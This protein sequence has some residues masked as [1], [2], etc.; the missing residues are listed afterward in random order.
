[1]RCE[2]HRVT[3]FEAGAAVGGTW[4]YDAGAGV[5]SSMY[6]ALRT[7]LP[8]EL[9]AFADLPFDASAPLA[10]DTRRYCG[11]AEVLAY[12]ESFAARNA[13]QPLIRFRTRVQRATPLWRSAADAQQLPGPQWEV[14]TVTDGDD[15]PVTAVFDALVVANGHYSSPRLPAIEGL[16][17]FPGAVSHTH[18]YRVPAP[19]AGK[20]VLV[21]GAAASG[22]DISRDVAP[23]AAAVLLS[24]AAFQTE[25]PLAGGAV[26]KRA[27]LVRLH[28]DG[29]AEFA[30]GAR[31]AVDAV[32]F[33]TGYHFTFPFL[34]GA[35]TRT[36]RRWHG[37]CR[38]GRVGMALASISSRLMCAVRQTRAL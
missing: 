37:I 25:G 31:D 23:L 36:Q 12:L 1:L 32:L 17:S 27:M 15:A 3:V 34:D 35:R 6:S 2:G 20:R 21:V 13:L 7:N 4:R 26:A 16:A 30:D 29:T 9:M 33:A 19:F 11:H 18:D 28:A 24:A 5:H 22:E 8:R 10:G 14:S 38:H